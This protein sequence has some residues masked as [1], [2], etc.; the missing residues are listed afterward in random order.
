[1]ETMISYCGLECTTCPAFVARL[2]DDDELRIK[3]AS[4]W[5]KQFNREM[6]KDSID[7]AGCLSDGPHGPYCGMCDIRTCGLEKGIENCAH[8][9]DYGCDKLAKVHNMDK[10][11]KERL[12]A[13]RAAR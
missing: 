13:I 3:T 2:N 8:C 11:P 7:C 4:E 9:A 6:S 10:A 1:M 5:S 12:D